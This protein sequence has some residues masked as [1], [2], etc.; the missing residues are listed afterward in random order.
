MKNVYF[1]MLCL[2]SFTGSAQAPDTIFANENHNIALFFPEKI[3]QGIV[4]AQ[5][6]IFSYNEEHPQYFGLL[7]ALPGPSS[8]LLVFTTDGAVYSFIVDHKKKLPQLTYFLGE[9]ESLG[10]EVRKKAVALEEPKAVD[11]KRKKEI[12]SI[13]GKERYLESLSSY[14]LNT[15][16]G[17]LKKKNRKGISLQVNEIIHYR[18]EVFIVFELKNTSGISFEP[19]YL[20]VYVSKGNKRKNASYQKLLKEPVFRHRFPEIVGDQQRKR[21]VYVFPK[22]TIGEGE[23]MEI[24]LREKKGNRLV[25]TKI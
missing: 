6:Y 24:E 2:V 3:R 10:N 1:V 17:K 4:G 22:F 7:K 21:F 18:D 9:E 19:E 20:R 8:N 16:T 12:D 14:Y 11:L 13:A 5:N 15:S 23:R 25:M